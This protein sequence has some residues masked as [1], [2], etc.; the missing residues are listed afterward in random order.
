[1][2][3]NECCFTWF[4]KRAIRSVVS[5]EFYG[6]FGIFAGKWTRNGHWKCMCLKYSAHTSR[7]KCFG[8][9]LKEFIQWQD[10]INSKFYLNWNYK[11]VYLDVAGVK[12]F[13]FGLSERHHSSIEKSIQIVSKMLFTIENS[14]I[15]NIFFASSIQM[16]NATERMENV[17]NCPK[18]FQ[19]QLWFCESIDMSVIFH[20]LLICCC[21]CCFKN[22]FIIMYYMLCSASLLWWAPHLPLSENES[23]KNAKTNDE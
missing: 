19:C 4:S 2:S 3:C 23:P 20:Y 21:C 5:R 12:Y 14:P 15:E 17:E 9:F 6:I 8:S 1:M 11:C 7:S 13:F 18:I 10:C 22:R 16:F